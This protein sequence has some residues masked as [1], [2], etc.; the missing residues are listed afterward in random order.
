MK[1]YIQFIATILFFCATLESPKATAQNLV[2]NPN[3]EDT[4]H[5][6]TG[7][8]QLYSTQ[9]W[10]TFGYTPDYFNGCN[11]T[12]VSVPNSVLGYQYAH[13]GNGMAGL[14]LWRKPNG[15]TGPDT[16][17]YMAAELIKNLNVGLKYYFSC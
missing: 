10:I 4:V 3:F 17:E 9:S 7:L 6:P 5:C 15:P 8:A 2:P 11:S 16:R 14:V 1:K 13:S 12:G